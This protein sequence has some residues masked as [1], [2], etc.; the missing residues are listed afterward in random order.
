MIAR[1]VELAIVLFYSKKMN[2]TIRFR[3]SDLFVR[4][5][6]LFRDFLRY[7][8]PVVLNELMWGAGASMNSA[9]IGHLAAPLPPQIP[10]RR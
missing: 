7:S 8:I 3:I 2:R 10:W 6:F 4:D 5:G 1:F 9:V